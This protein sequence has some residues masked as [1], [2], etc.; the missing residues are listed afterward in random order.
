MGDEHHILLLAGSSEA[1]GIAEALS[2]R[3]LRY[4]V[5]LSEPPRGPA[6][7][8]Q[9]PQLRRFPDASAMQAA[10]AQKG[11]TA[12][13]DAGHVFD[14]TAR[15]QATAAATALGLPFLRV[16]RPAWDTAGQLHWQTAPDVASANRLIPQGARVFCTTGWDSLTDYA[17]FRGAVLMLRQTR[18]HDRPAPYPF[19]EL[20]FGD[21]PFDAQQEEALFAK[22]GVDVLVCRNIGGAASRPKLDAAI[23]LGLDVILL[24]RPARSGRLHVVADVGTALNWVEEL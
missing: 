10:L 7:L 22:L 5:W 9:V 21:P 19:V 16:E 24:D 23:A 11:F 12:L 3:G 15:E 13:I 8:P 20:M 14:R 4:T 17:G 18:K 1:R 2:A 6:P